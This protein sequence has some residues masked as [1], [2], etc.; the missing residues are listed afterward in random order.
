MRVAPEGK[1]WLCARI[2]QD[3]KPASP[4][5]LDGHSSAASVSRIAVPSGGK[6][7]LDSGRKAL[8]QSGSGD[9]AQANDDAG[10]DSQACESKD[11]PAGEAPSCAERPFD[12]PPRQYRKPHRQR[13]QRDGHGQGKRRETLGARKYEDRP[14]PEIE[15]IGNQ[16]DENNRPP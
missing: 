9:E 2:T 5:L 10:H 4:D 12:K 6:N 3:A 1:R 11:R 14:M 15:R 13:D 16:P 8:R 7:T